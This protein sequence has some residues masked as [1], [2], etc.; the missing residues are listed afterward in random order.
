MRKSDDEL[1]CGDERE[2]EL[3]DAYY[4]ESE[5]IISIDEIDFEYDELEDNEDEEM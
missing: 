3:M 2:D 4:N 5:A 1:F